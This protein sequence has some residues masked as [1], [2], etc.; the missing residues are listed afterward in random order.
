M[1]IAELVNHQIFERTWRSPVEHARF[2]VISPH[3]PSWDSLV[4]CEPHGFCGPR[5]LKCA[6]RTPARDLPL[7]PGGQLQRGV[8]VRPRKRAFTNTPATC[9]AVLQTGA[10]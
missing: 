6:A 2:S 4:V 9:G 3:K 1:R 7:L 8:V 5:G 10:P